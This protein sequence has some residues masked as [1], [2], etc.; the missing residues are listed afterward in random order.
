MAALWMT[1]FKVVYPVHYLVNLT[2]RPVADNFDQIENARRVLQ[3]RTA[4]IKSNRTKSSTQTIT[5][6][7]FKSMSSAN[8]VI[9]EGQLCVPRITKHTQSID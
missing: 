2:I 6:K 4:F 3:D 5:R 7:A 9:E 8:V 1:D